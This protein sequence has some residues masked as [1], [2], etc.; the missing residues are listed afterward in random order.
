MNEIEGCLAKEYEN[1]RVLSIAQLKLSERLRYGI[2]IINYSSIVAH[3]LP[4]VSKTHF[5]CRKVIFIDQKNNE[6]LKY[7]VFEFEDLILQETT[8]A[9]SYNL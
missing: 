5:Q 2:P 3:L 1:L 4:F 6:I 9:D 7:L 8:E